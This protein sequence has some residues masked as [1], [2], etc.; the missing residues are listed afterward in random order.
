MKKQRSRQSPHAFQF[1]VAQ[2][3]KQPSGARRVYDIED[4]DAPP[5]DVDVMLVAP[6]RGHLQFMRVGQGILVRGKLAT[7]V[8]LECTRCLT[9]FQSATQFE[10]EEEFKPTLDINTGTRLVQEDG[11]DQATLID[12][13]HILD[14]GEIVRQDLMLSLP[15]SPVCR[16][17]CRGL[18]PICGQDRNEASCDCQPEVIDPRWAALKASFEE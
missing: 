5:L 1:N 17:D 4:A 14:L 6:F 15:P 10:I 7:T 11:Q 18:C 2:L 16:P 12:E 3:L 9:T 8:E 13:R